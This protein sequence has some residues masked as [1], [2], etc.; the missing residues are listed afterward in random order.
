MEPCEC[1]NDNFLCHPA[2]GCVCKQGYG[3]KNCD[4]NFLRLQKQEDNVGSNAGI[5]VAVIM[6]TVIFVTIVVLLMFY[7]KRRVSNLKTEIAHVQY[8]ANPSGFSPDQN[9][10]DNPVYTY[11]GTIKR[12]NEL[13]LNNARIVNNFEKASNSN[14]EKAR[15]GI[16]C[17]STD[18]EEY[19]TKGRLHFSFH[20]NL[21]NTDFRAVRYQ[22]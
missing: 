8:I 20:T 12:D 13:L 4:S 3:G 17:C 11:Q 14:M 21:S 2:D 6:V 18:D 9:H 19:A 1:P 15:L 10:F 16:A 5:I 22:F 7:Y